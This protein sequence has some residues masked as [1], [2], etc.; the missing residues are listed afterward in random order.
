MTN[1]VA[2]NDLN[3]INGILDVSGIGL[4]EIFVDTKTGIGSM[5]CNANML[6]LLALD[7]HLPAEECYLWWYNRIDDSYKEHVSEAVGKM[8]TDRTTLEIEYPW[9]GPNSLMYVR[10][11]GS[12]TSITDEKIHLSGY[13]QDISELYNTK[14]QLQQQLTNFEMSCELGNYAVFELQHSFGANSVNAVRIIANKNFSS[15][16]ELPTI[17]ISSAEWDLI[18]SYFKSEMQESWQALLDYNS[19][20][21]DCTIKSEFLCKVG[22]SETKWL[23]LTYKA[24]RDANSKL[25]LIG[26]L[27]DITNQKEREIALEEAK[28][29][30]ESANIAK[31][32]FLANMSHEI[33]TPMNAVLNF[34]KFMEETDLT[35]MQLD[36]V[37]KI[38]SSGSLMLNIL[39]D[40]LD[41]S[42][43]E[44]NKLSLEFH[45][46]NTKEEFKIIY[47]MLEQW[48]EEKDIS[49][50]ETFSEEIP[51][52][53]VGDALRVR[54]ILINLLNN[55][56]KF[57]PTGGKINLELTK[58]KTI[59]DVVWVRFQLS[60]S[61]IGMTEEQLGRL[62][63]A[64]TQ[65]DPSI[66]RRFGGTGLG[67]TICHMLV[68]L[69]GGKIEVESTVNVGTTFIVEI[70]F[71]CASEEEITR[72]ELEKQ[73]SA[74][75][76]KFPGLNCLIA[77]D[78]IINQQV[79]LA[80]LSSLKVTTCMVNNG[81]EALDMFAKRDDFD[82]I[83]MDIQMP[84][85]DG[86]TATQKLRSL[87]NDKAKN[88]PIFALTA[89]AMRGDNAKSIAHGMNTHL[90]KP[91]NKLE[92]CQALAEYFPKFIEGK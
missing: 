1:H 57:T 32:T 33:R 58:T 20:E 79:I 69:M 37:Q 46:Y 67:L 86:Y 4:W 76:Y 26:Y 62:F 17:M 83:F 92:I 47:G 5:H 87:D 89:N 88:I 41:F 81:Q 49:F 14:I 23:S 74:K 82:C 29:S 44:A 19:W 48:I 85:M 54:Q 70:P 22:E 8:I 34:A 35:P 10:C 61:G 21:I 60:D 77:E 28:K 80:L 51:L 78:N 25:R 30:A 53:V 38:H 6:Q 68:G 90:T 18:G 45:P 65:A 40:I 63:T 39:N 9:H 66:T 84:V 15:M 13:H 43:I 52:Y 72:L 3:T 7:K 42:K 16:F 12:A 91:L 75:D 64:F 24:I 36:Y 2:C 11:R 73:T 31:S 71:R 50:A 27:K 55:A 59:D 56:I